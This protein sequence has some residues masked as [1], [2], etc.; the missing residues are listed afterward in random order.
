[1][2]GTSK[3]R[4]DVGSSRIESSPVWVTVERGNGRLLEPG[5]FS[6]ERELAWVSW[7]QDQPQLTRKR[8]DGVED[9][10]RV[11][12]SPEWK[13]GKNNQG[14]ISGVEGIPR[15]PDLA[16]THL[17]SMGILDFTHTQHTLRST[18]HTQNTLQGTL[19]LR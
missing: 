1:M 11:E 12:L 6:R 4:I 3:L 18:Q 9:K 19:H 13:E 10:G 8:V 2:P 17:P 16:A 5:N 15:V 14:C 7:K